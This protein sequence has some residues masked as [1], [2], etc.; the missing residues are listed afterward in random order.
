LWDIV[1]QFDLPEYS[2]LLARFQAMES[3]IRGRIAGSDAPMAL[4]ETAPNGIRELL[5]KALAFSRS[6]GFQDAAGAIEIAIVSISGKSAKLDTSTAE[7]HLKHAKA[8]LLREV[9]RRKYISIEESLCKYVDQDQMFGMEVSRVFPFA[10]EDIREAGNCISIGSGAA[11]VFHLMRAVEYALR[12]L[13]QKLRVRLTH[14]GATLPLEFADWNCVITGIN[15]RIAK[16]RA[17]SPGPKKQQQLAMYSDAADHCLYMKDIWRNSISHAR[18]PY[19]AT[20]ALG[21]LERVTAFMNSVASV[22]A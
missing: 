16:A 15:N 22:V 8:A 10:A 11:T 9:A 7:S 14:K 20:E 2:E 18:K 5:S 19:S 6:M 13:A 1:D 3:H 17:L 12:K 4:A 21:V